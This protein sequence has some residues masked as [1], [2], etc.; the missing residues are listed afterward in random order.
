MGSPLPAHSV[1][2]SA[3]PALPGRT[4]SALRARL[5]EAVAATFAA[6]VPTLVIGL[7]VAAVCT[8]CLL[9]AGRSAAAERELAAT[10]DDAGTRVVVVSDGTGT[11]G[12]TG[13]AIPRVGN[14]NEVAWAVGL[15]L[16]TQV[17]NSQIPGATSIS[18]RTVIGPQP[19]DIIITAGRWPQPGEAATTVAAAH[20]LGLTAVAGAITD[21]TGT[22]RAV[23]GIISVHGVLADLGA[24]VII[25]SAATSDVPVPQMVVVATAAGDVPQLGQDLA[26]IAGTNGT[27]PPRITLPTELAQI[28]AAASGQLGRYSRQT[29]ALLLIVGLALVTLTMIGAVTSKRRD[30][31]RLRA[32][33]ASRTDILVLVAT[34]ALLPAVLGSLAGIVAGL[35]INRV[36]GY[37][38]PP[39]TFTTAVAVLAVLTSVVAAVPAATTAALR[40]PVRLLR[41]P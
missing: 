19:P 9:T 10:L 4:L 22:T 37:D 18:A 6:R 32:L 29:A 25:S 11:A 7:V 5:R 23:V 35:V 41:V 40:E 30:H 12:L 21:E 26:A 20:Q 17:R 33:G 39:G 15:G 16:F 2:S 31:G 27:T 1:P 14:L 38:P 28:A 8:A 34:Q 24:D 3:E 36:N 13:S